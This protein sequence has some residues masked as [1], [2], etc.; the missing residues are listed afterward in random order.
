MLGEIAGRPVHDGL[1]EVLLLKFTEFDAQL[2]AHHG[3]AIA[4]REERGLQDLY[5]VVESVEGESVD[6]VVGLL[7]L[8]PLLLHLFSH[9]FLLVLLKRVPSLILLLLYL[10]LFGY[11]FDGSGIPG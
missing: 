5:Q 1:T 4:A 6:V 2:Y 3:V 10:F 9:L 11:G 7:L 8:L